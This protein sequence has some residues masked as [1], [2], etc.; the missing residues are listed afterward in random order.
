MEYLYQLHHTLN[1]II[2]LFF[3]HCNL[4][5]NNALNP[6]PKDKENGDEAKRLPLLAATL[7][8]KIVE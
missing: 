4:N 2:L 8:Q 6:K 7:L 1:I 5:T 3:N